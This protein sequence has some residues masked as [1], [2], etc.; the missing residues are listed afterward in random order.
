MKYKHDI[1]TIKKLLD[2]YK[3][4]KIVL[5]PPYQRNPI[6]TA[7]AQQMLIDTIKKNQPIPNFFVRLINE[8]SIE[9]V[10]GQQRAR[11]I[12]AF[13]KGIISDLEGEKYT[14]GDFNLKYPLSVTIITE[15]E[16]NESI[17]KFYALVNSSGLR[18]NRPE[19]KKAEYYNTIFLALITDLAS[20]SEFTDLNLFTKP[21]ADRM[22]DIEFVSELVANLS[23]GISDKKEKVDFLYDKD[24]SAEESE[25][26]KSQFITIIKYIG[27][28][29]KIYPINKTRYKQRNDFYT[30]FDF[31]K[32]LN[33]TADM[34]DTMLYYYQILVKIGPFIKPSQ[35]D[36]DPLMDYALHC[37]S[38][39]NSK[40]AREERQRFFIDLFLNEN[41]EANETQ[42]AILNFFGKD[43]LNIVSKSEKMTINLDAIPST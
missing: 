9:M 19:L 36:C 11:T 25:E 32:T 35:E 40:T 13:I 7:N 18:L 29:N 43:S 37:V 22:N 31:I 33:P 8:D 20:I 2:L 14:K 16:K 41:S 39:S 1:W 6:W 24:I 23:F 34:L 38:Q 42:K 5:N 12:F 17:E 30:L 3:K 15:L 10:D 28:F 26:L 21:S 4:G 27:E